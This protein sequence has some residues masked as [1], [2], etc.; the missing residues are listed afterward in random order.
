M[1]DPAPTVTVRR[2]PPRWVWFVVMFAA[3]VLWLYASKQLHPPVIAQLPAG[4]TP[5]C[6]ELTHG[7]WA[8]VETTSQ[9]SEF[10][11]SAI[12]EHLLPSW[13]ATPTGLLL[14]V[15]RTQF[16]ANNQLIDD[17]VLR[18][19]TTD[20]RR[21]ESSPMPLDWGSRRGGP[22]LKT[23]SVAPTRDAIW[24][25]AQSPDRQGRFH[26]YDLDPETL[27]VRRDQ[28]FETTSMTETLGGTPRLICSLLS[29]SDRELGVIWEIILPDRHLQWMMMTLDPATGTVLRLVALDRLDVDAYNLT[30][31][32][33]AP[34]G[35]V[36]L[37]PTGDFPPLELFDPV[38]G[39]VG[40]SNF[41]LSNVFF[42]NG[43]R[44]VLSGSL[45][46]AVSLDPALK[47]QADWTSQYTPPP[48]YRLPASF[49]YQ[50]VLGDFLGRFHVEP[51]SE[52][53]LQLAFNRSLHL[54]ALS[55]QNTSGLGPALIPLTGDIVTAAAARYERV[56]DAGLWLFALDDHTALLLQQVDEA[57]GFVNGLWRFGHVDLVASSFQWDGWVPDHAP[58][59]EVDD[60]YRLDVRIC[61]VGEQ[62]LL[63]VYGSGMEGNR[64]AA[65]AVSWVMF[66]PPP[67]YPI[68]PAGRWLL[69]A[70]GQ[71]VLW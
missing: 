59:V 65:R 29:I 13:N 64:A 2:P 30:E 12:E 63:G 41:Q 3:A 9:G 40:A 54:T 31:F 22:F 20:G 5:A 6:T 1:T 48:A 11:T 10:P 27:A 4:W 25:A 61:P 21:A 51:L 69:A 7:E 37:R 15:S 34:A 8:S 66:A 36:V 39:Q 62:W 70:Q 24:V 45:E 33:L 53:D 42:P 55:I 19:Q 71:R 67:G 44:A 49:L 50:G 18:R 46:L 14:F 47:L 28:I 23:P 52:M 38:T 35:A 56:G 32:D 57:S 68:L 16:D 43:Q 58:L 26:L 60:P 17:Y